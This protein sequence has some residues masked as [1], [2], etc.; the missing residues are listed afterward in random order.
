MFKIFNVILNRPK[1]GNSSIFEDDLSTLH[2][3]SSKPDLSPSL[4]SELHGK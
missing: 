2:Q 1:N 4:T 3:S